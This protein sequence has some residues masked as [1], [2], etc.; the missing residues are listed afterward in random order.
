MSEPTP[1]G[2]ASGPPPTGNAPTTL[3]AYGTRYLRITVRHHGDGRLTWTRSPGPAHHHPQRV[4]GPELRALL[5]TTVGGPAA[6]L[7]PVGAALVLGT[8]TRL[9]DGTAGLTYEVPG[10]TSVAR[11]LPTGDPL[12][13][14]LALR[15]LTGAGRTLRRLHTVPWTG[16]DRPAHTGVDRLLH[17]LAGGEHSADAI[18]LHARARARLGPGRWRRLTEWATAAAHPD[19]GD[20]PR[21][22]HGAPSTGWLV[23][24]P[25][26]DRTALLC[27]EEVTWGDPGLDLGWLL[28]ELH[29]LRAASE[30]GLGAV[31]QSPRADY[32]GAARALLDGYRDGAP[33]GGPAPP[34]G[35]AR[36]ATLRL[37]VHMRD[38]AC[39]VGW[40]EDL[41]G[42]ADLLAD[43]LDGE[44]AATLAW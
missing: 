33:E 7:R 44:G 23:P 30:R 35:T 1:G 43:T 28:G 9:A 22:L 12:A 20:T 8:P 14:H 31:G 41:T 5:R 34:E 17:W 18:R 27:G 10:M 25:T 40:H 37:A 32:A 38:F 42:Y 26:G 24:A 16:Q 11:L 6:P 21:L 15:A 19:D 13:R 39:F 2:P 4:V 36:A 29:E 3:R